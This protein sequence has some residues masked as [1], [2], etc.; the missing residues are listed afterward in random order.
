M[1]FVAARSGVNLADR[2]SA[3]GLQMAVWA[4]LTV[5]FTVHPLL[6]DRLFVAHYALVSILTVSLIGT[7]GSCTEVRVPRSTR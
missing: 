6:A 3:V 2:W 4:A 1:G 7:C 5:Q